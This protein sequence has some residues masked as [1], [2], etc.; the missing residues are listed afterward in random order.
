M[1]SKQITISASG[2]RKVHYLAANQPF[3]ESNTKTKEHCPVC[4]TNPATA[5]RSQKDD[6]LESGQKGLSKA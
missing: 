1:S 3:A 4:I 6:E 5:R 2:A